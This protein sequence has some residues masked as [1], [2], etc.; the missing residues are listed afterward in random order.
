L[1]SRGDTR[2]FSEFFTD[3]TERKGGQNRKDAGHFAT[4]MCR[5]SFSHMCGPKEVFYVTNTQSEQRK[6][7]KATTDPKKVEICVTL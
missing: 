7:S 2:G 4:E 1:E 6:G 5:N 3:Q